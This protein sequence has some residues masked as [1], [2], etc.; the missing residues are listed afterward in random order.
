M[1]YSLCLETVFEGMDFYDRIPLAKELGL[2]GIEFWEPEKYCAEKIGRIARQCDISVVSC[3]IFD[4]RSTTLNC[5]WDRIKANIIKTAAFGR[6]AGCANFIGLAGNV[7]CKADAQKV[8]ITENLKRAAEVCE[9][10]GVNLFVEAL[11]SVADHLGYYLDSSYVGFEIIKAVNSPRVK[12]LYDIYHMQ[13]MEGNIIQNAA[14]NVRS[15]G[16]VHSAGV[17]GRHEPQTGE[18]NYPYVI[19]RLE[20]AGYDQFFGFEYFPTYDNRQS[21]KDALRYV[22][23]N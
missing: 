18:V 13:L 17:P 19:K 11:N 14:A 5:E 23:G 3:C 4:T 6:E 1:K 2:D 12:L 15:I 10:E 8:V 16:H 7:M 20:E 21:V 9:K 22:K